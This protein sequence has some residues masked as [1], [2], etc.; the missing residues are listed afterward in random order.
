MQGLQHRRPGYLQIT[1]YVTVNL[2][3][4]GIRWDI[5][6]QILRKQFVPQEVEIVGQE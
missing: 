4:Q 1:V 6:K 5:Q 3:S 2:A